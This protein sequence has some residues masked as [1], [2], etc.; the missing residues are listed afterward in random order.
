MRM[1]QKNQEHKKNIEKIIL[2]LVAGVM[3]T[4][5]LVWPQPK[6]RPTK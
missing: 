2:V 4:Y 6:V 1:R 3:S 5:V